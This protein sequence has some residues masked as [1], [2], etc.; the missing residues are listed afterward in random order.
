MHP[1]ARELVQPERGQPVSSGVLALPD[2]AARAAWPTRSRAEPT[3][4]LQGASRLGSATAEPPLPLA[5]SLFKSADAP[6][7]YCPVLAHWIRRTCSTYWRMSCVSPLLSSWLTRFATSCCA[8]GGVLSDG[9]GR[10]KEGG[11]A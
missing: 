3:R 6:L 1:Q 4:A 5:W 11:F 7:L 10:V 9:G 8:G 2:G